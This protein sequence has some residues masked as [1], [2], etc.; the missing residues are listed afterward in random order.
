MS[1][2]RERV[3]LALDLLVAGLV[4]YLQK[5]LKAIYGDDWH[6]AARGSFRDDRG[7]NGRTD[8]TIRWDAHALLT[9]MWDQWNRAFR[10]QLGHADRSLVS[11]LREFRNQWA[12]QNDFEFDDTYRM[13]DSVERLLKSAGS[14]LSKRVHREKQDLLRTQFIREAKNAY[15]NSQLNRRMM[16][17]LA[18]YG[19]CCVAIVTVILQFFGLQSWM[20]A[21]FVVFTFS[22]LA[23]QR[24]Q[25]HPPMIF[26]PH[27]CGACRRIIYGA[28]CPYCDLPRKTTRLRAEAVLAEQSGHETSPDGTPAKP[29]TVSA[30]SEIRQTV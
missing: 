19:L 21:G 16:Q 14:P 15:R 25:S 23:Y 9:V 8:K 2:D 4:P 26:G 28:D 20:V 7:R 1:S 18:I 24:L 30:E 22:Y 11:E 3:T 5:H 27:E 29:E 17:D 13:L 10:G 12:H 6:R